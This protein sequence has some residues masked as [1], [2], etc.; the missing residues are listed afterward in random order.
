MKNI[1]DKGSPCSNP[2]LCCICG[3]GCLFSRNLE[4]DVCK[5][6]LIHALHF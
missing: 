3:P 1:S 6:V 5:I 4:V 2:L